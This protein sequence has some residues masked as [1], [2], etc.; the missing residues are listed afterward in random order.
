MNTFIETQTAILKIHEEM[1]AYYEYITTRW[2]SLLKNNQL[3]WRYDDR[4]IRMVRKLETIQR[5]AT[6]IKT[7][8]AKCVADLEARGIIPFVPREVFDRVMKRERNLITIEYLL[9]LVW[10]NWGDS[11]TADVSLGSPLGPGQFWFAF[12]YTEHVADRM[13]D[14]PLMIQKIDEETNDYEG[15]DEDIFLDEEDY[16]KLKDHISVLPVTNLY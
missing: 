13:N 12:N 2:P 1:K 16:I 6:H 3:K 10:V 8:I 14:S 7:E 5:H 9:S 11:G 4:T 15:E